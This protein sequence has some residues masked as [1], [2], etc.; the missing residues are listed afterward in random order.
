MNVLSKFHV[1]RSVLIFPVQVQ[2]WPDGGARV[3]LRGIN[4][5]ICFQDGLL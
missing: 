4:V 2:I 5:A 1:N 3:N